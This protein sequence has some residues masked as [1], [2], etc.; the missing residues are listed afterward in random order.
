MELDPI[1]LLAYMS[2]AVNLLTLMAATVAYAVFRARRARRQARSNPPVANAAVARAA[3]PF[4]PAFLSPY[5]PGA[6]QAAAT[7]FAAAAL[8]ER[9]QA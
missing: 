7:P 3:E 9:A 5:Q 2:V 4:V 8:A 6:G 1:V